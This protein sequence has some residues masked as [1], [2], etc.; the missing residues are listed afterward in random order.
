MKSASSTPRGFTL[1]EVMVVVAIIAILAVMAVPSLMG[2]Y[3]RE[4]IVE[5]VTLAKLAKDAVGASWATT[6]TLPD[7]NAAAGL[8]AADKIVNNVV[9]SVTV[10]NGAVHILFGNRA[11]GALQGKIL[12]LR[13][14][15]VADAPVVPVAWVCAFSKVPDQMTVMGTNRTSI[16]RQ[17]LPVNCL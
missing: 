11:N 15:I 12:T 13:P 7:D 16:E 6:K 2:K 1:I 4:H 3:V 14:A 8:P 17:H 5:G 9:K 10:E